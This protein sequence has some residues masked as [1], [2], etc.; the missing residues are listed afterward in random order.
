MTERRDV[1]FVQFS[2]DDVKSAN[3]TVTLTKQGHLVYATP[4]KGLSFKAEEQGLFVKKVA[5]YGMHQKLG[6]DIEFTLVPVGLQVQLAFNEGYW[7]IGTQTDAYANR[8]RC[9][10]TDIQKALSQVLQD[11]YGL[12]F[13]DFDKNAVYTLIF[14]HRD[15]SPVSSNQVFY[16][17]REYEKPP[18][19]YPR[20]ESFL[21]RL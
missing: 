6:T 5:N 1:G 11:T 10:R 20:E 19:E 13:N 21:P 4:K 18:A 17:R 8:K 14:A 12:T 15:L 9:G 3:Q 16:V 7:C 2:T